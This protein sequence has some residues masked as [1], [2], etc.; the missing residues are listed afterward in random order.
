MQP[1]DPR[2]PRSLATHC[3]LGLPCPRRVGA[4]SAIHLVRAA[5]FSRSDKQLARLAADQLG[6]W[7]A[8]DN[9]S[10]RSTAADSR[11]AEPSPPADVGGVAIEQLLSE[12]MRSAAETLGADTCSLMVMDAAKDALVVDTAYG[13]AEGI[14]H[15]PGRRPG[16]GIASYVMS[17]GRPVILGDLTRDPQLRGLT[18]EP[19][20]DIKC[21]ICIPI[22]PREGLRGVVSFNRTGNSDPFTQDDLQL[23]RTVAMQLGPCVANAR[24]Y[25]QAAEQLGEM[26]AIT[27]MTDA[28]TPAMGMRRVAELLAP[29]IAEAASVER[30]RLYLHDGETLSLAAHYGYPP[31]AKPASTLPAEHPGVQALFEAQ[32]VLI[33]PAK[34]L[35]EGTSDAHAEYCIAAPVAHGGRA[36]GILC[37]DCDDEP[38]LHAINLERLE[39]VLAR[40]GLAFDNAS[41]QERLREN[42]DDLYRLYNSVQRISASF[43]PEEILERTAHEVKL[44]VG[45]RRAGFAPLNPAL[46]DLPRRSDSGWTMLDLDLDGRVIG[47]AQSMSAPLLVAEAPGDLSEDMGAIASEILRLA[48]GARALVIP[49]AHEHGNLGLVVGWSFSRTPREREITSAAGVCAHGAALLRKA[50]DYQAAINK[51]SLEL[52]A[53]YQL[54]E[55]ISTATSFESALRSVLDIALSMVDYDEGLVFIHDAETGRLELAACRGVEMETVRAHAPQAEPGSMYQW[56]FAEGKAFISTDIGQHGSELNP[57]GQVLRSAMAVPLVVGNEAIGVLA[58]HSARVRAYTEDHV[59]M[60]SIVASQAAAIYRALQSLG[61]LSRYTNNILQ[62][63]VAGVIGLDRAGRVVIWSPAAEAILCLSTADAAG[64]DLMTL[65]RSV[66]EEQG[67]SA[68]RSIE[69][70][71]VVAGRVLAEGEPLLEHELRFDREGAPPR[72][73]LTGCTP[74]RD[75]SGELAG[76]VLLVEDITERKRIDDRMRQMSQLAAVGHLAANVAHEIRNP[77]SAIKTAAQFLSTEYAAERLISDF[78]GIINEECDRLGKV[79]TDF[80]TYARPNEPELERVSLAPVVGGAVAATA[81]EM[82]E[83]GI[84]VNWRP[85]RSLPNVW[86]DPDAIRQVFINLLINAAQAVGQNGE[87]TVSLHA[88]NGGT[89]GPSVEAVVSD[90]GPGIPDDIMD[91]IWTPFFSTKAKGTGLGLS[92]VRKAV[93]SHGGQVWAE[94]GRTGGASFH[95]RLPVDRSMAARRLEPAAS[96]TTAAKWQQLELFDADSPQLWVS[97]AVGDARE[98]AHR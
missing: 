12:A 22:G 96:P 24:L 64:S 84:Q 82:R 91:R 32:P 89:E 67:R 59:K 3:Y 36:F 47:A 41:T 2:L 65:A 56:V 95:I 69:S 77:L 63:I 55:E 37:V 15:D 44:L 73:L 34:T 5:P 13:L 48:G 45:C 21:S 17:L 20:P 19:R 66:G 81:A 93:E 94:G 14:V 86:I 18:I 11:A 10:T 6:E 39:K 78:A 83:R 27:R 25:Q 98:G 62:S 71:A 85:P 8:R 70:L 50:L 53:L 60:L 79:A 30:Y 35:G 33:K 38:S 9:A 1:G 58:I 16:E 76:A 28:V 42:L 46:S 72:M 43:E 49:V 26:T 23:A 61:S 57:G 74:L 68:R 97:V 92:I 80:L 87:I 88:S 52:S 40:A 51:R 7:T 31:S 75:S 29:G 54:C 4:G 90:T